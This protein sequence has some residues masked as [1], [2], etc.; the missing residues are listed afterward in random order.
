M[1]GNRNE[2][3]NVQCQP[4]TV[5]NTTLRA[6]ELAA[7]KVLAIQKGHRGVRTLVTEVIRDLLQQDSEAFVLAPGES[8][9]IGVQKTEDWRCVYCREYKPEHERRMG[10]CIACVGP[11]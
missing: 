9:V 1:A 7:L 5:L 10:T 6:D 11:A 3:D 8:G 2:T 4:N